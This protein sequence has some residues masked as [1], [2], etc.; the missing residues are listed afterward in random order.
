MPSERKEKAQ[1]ERPVSFTIHQAWIL[2]KGAF[3]IVQVVYIL[4][5]KSSDVHLCKYSMQDV[6]CQRADDNFFGIFHLGMNERYVPHFWYSSYERVTFIV[7]S[8]LYSTVLD[9]Y[10][11]AMNSL[12]TWSFKWAS[13]CTVLPFLHELRY[14]I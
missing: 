9:S 2:M 11:V 6:G 3:C 12:H 10:G 4:R 8:S 13:C 1:E 7:Q 14:E 5:T